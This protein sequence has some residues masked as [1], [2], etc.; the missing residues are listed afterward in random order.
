MGEVVDRHGFWSVQTPAAAVGAFV[1]AHRVRGVKAKP[2]ENGPHVFSWDYSWPSAGPSRRILTVAVV[3]RRSGASLRVDAKVVWIYPRSPREKVPSR[4]REITLRTPTV[5]LTV[6]DRGKVERI[7]RWFDALPISPPGVAAMCGPVVGPDISL[8]F[9]T[10][11]GTTLAR[12]ELP[13]VPAGVCD[14]IDFTIGGHPQTPLI[15]GY[16]PYRGSFVG[17]LKRLLGVKLLVR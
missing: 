4:V 8:S 17:R 10:A 9:R 5:N 16:G 1:E 14:P 3:P 12:A 7:I 15:D 13:P 11:S 6:T 2:S